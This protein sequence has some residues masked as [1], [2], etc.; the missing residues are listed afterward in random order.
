MKI[1]WLGSDRGALTD[2]ITQQWVKLTGKRVRLE[3]VPWLQG[4]IGK[5][6]GIGHDYFLRLA[7]EQGYVV[8]ASEG[9]RGLLNFEDLRG[10][11]FQPELVD[12]TVRSFYES[13]SEY[14]FESWSEWCGA[15][16]P[17]GMV[18]A[19]LF[20]RRLQQLNVPLN[21]L[22]TSGGTTSQV[23][24]LRDPQSGNVTLTAWIRMLRR[25]GNVLYAGS[26][27]VVRIP[28]HPNPCVK[29]VFPLP[30]GNAIVIMKP[31]VDAEG[32]FT[33]SSSGE[34]F[35]DPG[36]YFTVHR[37]G[38]PVSAR[39]VRTMRESIRVY[40]AD[41]PR[42]VRADHVLRIWRRVFLR[43]HYRLRRKLHAE[44]DPDAKC[45]SASSTSLPIGRTL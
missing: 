26:Y 6:T 43:L 36:F 21:S 17:F 10:P 45:I 5:T 28:G 12:R 20:S 16:K 40:R 30:N 25:T 11:S 39:Y 34:R 1:I 3:D 44:S 2:W 42:E 19:F 22:D 14:E 37:S 32:T 41:E 8:N 4:P 9:V 15:F 33:I 7:T 23:I 29:V 38:G 13:T 35:G 27:S 24:Q 18:L 31:E